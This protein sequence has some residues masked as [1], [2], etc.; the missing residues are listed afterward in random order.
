MHVAPAS[1]GMLSSRHL[2]ALALDKEQEAWNMFEDVESSEAD[3]HFA[4]LVKAVPQL[5]ALKLLI[6]ATKTATDAG[7]QAR[8]RRV[9]SAQP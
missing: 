7:L 1:C 9:C 5:R 8:P 2:T 3:E 6:C 4:A